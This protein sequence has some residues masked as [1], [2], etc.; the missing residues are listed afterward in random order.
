MLAEVGERA[1]RATILSVDD[2]D[3]EVLNVWHFS[4]YDRD[5]QCASWRVAYD[6]VGA[7]Q[8]PQ[9]V[10]PILAAL[11]RYLLR[12]FNA[13]KPNGPPS[14]YFRNKISDTVARSRYLAPPGAASAALMEMPARRDTR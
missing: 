5:R 6:R 1:C 10:P 12:C 14:G 11:L 4:S 2:E 13:S 7:F 9:A 8:E 3:G